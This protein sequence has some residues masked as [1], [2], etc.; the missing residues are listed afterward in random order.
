MKNK[1]LA[2]RASLDELRA[3]CG[4]LYQVLGTVGAPVK[5]LD[6]VSA[7]AAGEAIPDIDFLPIDELDFDAVREKQE[8]LNKIAMFLTPERASIIGRAGGQRS[9]ELKRAASRLNGRKG[10]RPRKDARA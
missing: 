5:V 1:N 3:L 2:D 4:A 8:R 7:A 9:T 10:G 6:A